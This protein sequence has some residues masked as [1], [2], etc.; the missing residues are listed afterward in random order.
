MFLPGVEGIFFHLSK[1][2]ESTVPADSHLVER[3]LLFKSN[4]TSHHQVAQFYYRRH[5]KGRVLT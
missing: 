5:R 3:A 2:E 4:E 1:K